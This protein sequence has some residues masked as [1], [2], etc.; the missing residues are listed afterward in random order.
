MAD[1]RQTL[2]GSGLETIGEV[3]QFGLEMIEAKTCVVVVAFE[4]ALPQGQRYLP[5]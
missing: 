5:N 1:L 4:C 2:T 3:Q